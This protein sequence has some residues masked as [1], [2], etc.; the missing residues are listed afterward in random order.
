MDRLSSAMVRASFGWLLAGFVLG[1]LM[2]MDRAVPGSWRRWATPTHGHMLFVGWFVQF[3]IGIAYWLLPRRRT[4][5]RPLG[6]DERPALAAAAALNL[7]LLLRA[8]A[9]PAERAGQADGWTLPMLAASAAL[10]VGA[11][12]VFVA[13]LWAR[14][15][16]RSA[17]ARHGTVRAEMEVNRRR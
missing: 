5:E 16:R 2:L 4:A 13:Q 12:A 11:V 14:V 9:E 7:G 17:R 8:A 6:Y 3:A 15:G 10:Q 1:A